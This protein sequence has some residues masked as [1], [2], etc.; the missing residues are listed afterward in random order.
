MSRRAGTEAGTTHA[1]RND[2][3]TI[4]MRDG[5]FG[6]LS[7]FSRSALNSLVCLEEIVPEAITLKTPQGRAAHDPGFSLI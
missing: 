7:R 1:A 4:L 2:G 3:S 6:S 5:I